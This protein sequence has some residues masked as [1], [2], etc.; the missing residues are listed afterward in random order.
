VYIS[1]G[2]HRRRKDKATFADINGSKGLIMLGLAYA[3]CWTTWK[4]C[5]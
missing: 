4:I 3:E 1:T 2:I 5:Y